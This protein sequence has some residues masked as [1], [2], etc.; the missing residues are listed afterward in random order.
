MDIIVYIIKLYIFI[1]LRSER[2]QKKCYL[3]VW[4]ANGAQFTLTVLGAFV[5]PA[6]VVKFSLK[7]CA[8]TVIC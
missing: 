3:G 8:I 7:K 1:I 5:S 4:I 6:A 2:T